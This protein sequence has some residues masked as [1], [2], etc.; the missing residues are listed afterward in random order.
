MNTAENTPEE[1]HRPPFPADRAPLGAWLRLVDRLI[2]REFA[3]AF[4]GE[5]VTRR[6]WMLLNAVAGTV[7]E[8][9]IGRRL[10]AGGKRITRLA[11]RGWITQDGDDWTLTDTGRAA[12]DRLSEK[13][14]TVRA[15]VAGA[16]SD[17]EFAH[18]KTSLAKVARGL[19]W[20]ETQPMPRGRGRKRRERGA[21]WGPY[22]H[23]HGFGGYGHEFGERRHGRHER[24]RRAF[25]ARAE[26]EHDVGPDR[27]GFS[28]GYGFRGR[29]AFER[30]H[31]VHG[32]GKRAART[33][34]RAFER[35]FSAGLGAAGAGGAASTPSAESASDAG[36]APSAPSAD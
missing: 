12:F 19:G 18:L 8:P 6:D 20:D 35:G 33:Y 17:D 16:L 24:M 9:G 30:H 15:K 4:D 23:G 25:A 13:V 3:A 26:C 36:S 29:D 22:G 14:D 10:A 28:P 31:R 7:E 32:G 27:G 2:D 34:E 1:E 11:D 5:D 21:G